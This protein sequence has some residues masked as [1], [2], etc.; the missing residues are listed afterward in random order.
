MSNLMAISLD[1][2][3]IHVLCL[4][5]C[6]RLGHLVKLVHLYSTLGIMLLASLDRHVL[7]P[8]VLNDGCTI[9]I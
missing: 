8:L 5:A 4:W 2:D 3:R 6:T 9:F 1:F 7:F